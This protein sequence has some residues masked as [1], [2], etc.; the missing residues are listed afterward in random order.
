M[1]KNNTKEKISCPNCKSKKIITISKKVKISPF[2]VDICKLETSK[3]K[4][5]E[6]HNCLFIFYKKR[7]TNHELSNLYKNYRTEKYLK[8]RN[9]Y[10]PWYTENFQNKLENNDK[11][12]IIRK[13][14]LMNILEKNK[15]SMYQDD[16][17]LDYGGNDGKLIQGISK[18]CY[19][20]DINK[21]KL[22]EGVKRF[23][24][25]KDKK[26]FK[27]ITCS[28]V[29]EHI[30]DPIF[31][32]KNMISLLKKDEGYLYIDVP[33]ENPKSFQSILIS[34]LKSIIETSRKTNFSFSFYTMHEHINFYMPKSLKILNEIH[35]MEIVEYGSTSR[36]L[37]FN[38]VLAKVKN[39]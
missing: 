19:V 25:K 10:E 34:G 4:L 13:N 3:T 2:I 26:K 28:N 39:L 15:I 36:S 27:L 22:T 32:I 38:Y 7:F 33:N 37:N 18:N 23:T 5:F 11:K 17:I 24:P 14:F 6:C 8:K 29:L 20:Y 16:N 9:S 35:N 1:Q 21:T 31:I 12:I 30:N